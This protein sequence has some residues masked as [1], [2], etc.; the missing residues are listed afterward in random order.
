MKPYALDSFELVVSPNMVMVDTNVLIAAFIP[1]GDGQHET[2][3]A[4]LEL[5][6]ESGIA[7]V[8]VPVLIEAWGFIVGSRKNRA[9][10]IAMIE[11]ALD[12]LLVQ[13]IP[14]HHSHAVEVSTIAIRYVRPPI[15]APAL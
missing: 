12:P 11:W 13:L 4:F 3:K 2:A 1:S 14:G 5:W 8:P 6:G 15:P 7:L 10:G 9:A